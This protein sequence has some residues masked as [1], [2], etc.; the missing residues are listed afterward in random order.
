MLLHIKELAS[1]LEA[2]LPRTENRTNLIERD[3]RQPRRKTRTSIKVLQPPKRPQKNLL[4]NLLR[5][6]MISH[7]PQTQPKYRPL[8]ASDDLSEE[9][10]LAKNNAA[11]KHLVR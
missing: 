8:M 5:I 6:M 7:R 2:I 10:P 3:P 9:L 11:A 1:P 4:R